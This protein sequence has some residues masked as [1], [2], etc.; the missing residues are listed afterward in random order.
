MRTYHSNGKTYTAKV[1]WDAVDPQLLAKEG[2]VVLAGRVEGTDLPTRLHIRV[3]A[4]TVK[5]A[6]VAEQWTGSVLPLAFASDSNDADPVAKVN[7]KVI[8]FTDAPANRWT[9]WGRDNAEDSVGILFGDSGILTKR[10]VDNLH[11][12]FHEDHGVG[13]PSEYVIEYY[14]GEQIPTVPN[15]PNRVKD[16]TD[17]PFNNPANWKEVSN[18][19]VEEPV[20][21]GKMNHFSFDKVDTYAVRIRMKTPEGKRG[22]SISEI[23][24]FANK[25]AAEEKSQV[26]IRVNGEVLPGVNPSVTDYYIDARDRAYPQ[27]EATASHHGL[28]TVVPSVHEGEPIRVIH[29]AEDGTILQEYH[30]HLTSDAEKLKQAVPVAVEAGRRF[31]KVGQDL[32]LPSTVGVYFKGDTG[33]E[34]KEL[35][36]DWQAIPADALSHEGSFT[37]EGKVLGYDLTA[38]LTVRVS[39]KTGEILSVNRDYNAEDT[40]AFASETNDLDPNQID[41]IDYINDGGYNEYYRWTNW[42]REP[43]QT[44]VFAGLIFKKNGQVTERLVNKVAVDF[45]ADQETGLPTKTVLERYIGPDFDV[46]DDYGNLKNLPDHPFN[47]ASNWEEIPYSLDY[48]FEPGYISNLS[49]NETR[50][51]AIRLRM[52]RDENL[53]GIGIIELSAYAPTEEAQATTD[54][55]IQVNGKDLEGFKPDVTEYHLEY[56]GERPIV[57]AQGKNGTAVTVIDAKSAN[58]P[59]LVK[60]VSEDGKLEKVYQLS[61]SAKAPTGSAI[62]EEGVK[63][64]VHTKPELVIEPEEMDF[65]RLERPNAD[66]PKGEKRVVQE[67]QKGRKLRLVEVSQENGVESRKE[68]DAFVE[69]DPV[70]EITEVGTKEVLPDTPQPDPQPQPEPQPEPELQPQPEPQ[71]LPSPERPYVSERPEPAETSKSSVGV[72]PVSQKGIVSEGKAVEK[73][74]QAPA[75][76]SAPVSEGTLPNTG[77]EESVASLVAGILAAGL[78]SAVLDDQKKRADKVKKNG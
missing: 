19:T 21:A 15:N 44:E 59:V 39:E 63:N 23:Q 49:F 57:S 34:R 77:T 64:L 55:T 35:T 69:L 65:E 45:F 53:K 36:V 40:R 71:P 37:L 6:N 4:N 78:A 47:Q 75:V 26:T 14:T 30:L 46:P 42:K 72:E 22:S 29:K 61:L 9:N 48:A 56:E 41:Y 31:V 16:E 12:G 74:A 11:V 73:I 7:D 27:V 8:S 43:D 28:A 13:A 60:V 38:Q 58:A 17:H 10:A 62:P 67:G 66:L 52:V 51:K 68:L 18:L 70:A 3:S 20:A 25:V 2:E 50:T 1:S 76:S 33:Y 5:G 24:V 32:V 54:V